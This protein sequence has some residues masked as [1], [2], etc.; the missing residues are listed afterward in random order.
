ML[1]FLVDDP[2]PFTTPVEIA[3]GV[4]W[5]RLPIPYRLDHVNVYLLRDG[6]RWV[7]VDTGVDDRPT[8]DAWTAILDG[9]GGVKSV[10]AILLTHHHPDHAGAAGWLHASTSAPLIASIPEW[11]ALRTNAGGRHRDDLRSLADH[12][13]WLGCSHEE[14]DIAGSDRARSW[15]H[16]SQPPAAFRAIG[17]GE[18]IRTGERRWRIILGAGH[19]PCP[20]LLWDKAANL[21]VAGDQILP[22]ITPYVG[23]T[24][25]RPAASPV[26]EYLTFLDQI[27]GVADA[28]TL[29]LPGHGLPFRGLPERVR[30]LQ[31]HHR[32]RCQSILDHCV[33]ASTVRTLAALLFGPRIQ[34]AL[35]MA[36]EETLSHANLLIEQ[37]LLGATTREGILLLDRKV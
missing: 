18:E 32:K 11:N 5:V 27:V 14:A 12:F 19:S 29:V 9:I 15:D 35:G 31:E 37:G 8:R 36:L 22:A 2:P 6:A 20:L 7:V 10:E 33:R 30:E 28:E 17:A 25:D 23:T 3:D 24:S 16:Y 13:R 34:G 1:Q 4:L 26:E 21:I